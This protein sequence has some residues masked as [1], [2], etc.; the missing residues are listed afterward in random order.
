MTRASISR[1]ARRDRP[2]GISH[3]G[4]QAEDE[5]ELAEVYDRLARAERPT[6][7]AKATTCCYAKSDKQWIADPQGVPWETFFTYG[8]STVYGEGSL[9]KLKELSEAT[10]CGPEAMPQAASESAGVSACCAP[11]G[12]TAAMDDAQ[13][14]EMVRARYRGIA[15]AA[16][17][18]SCCAPA[19]SCCGDTAAGTQ[20]D[21]ARQMGYSDAELAVVP[22]G[23]NLGLG[24][25]NP[26]AIAALK[27][28]EVVVDL[29]SGA[30]FD[31][32]L[33]A[34]Q[35][36][37]GG[38]VIGVDMTHEMLKKARENAA[39]ISAANVEFRLGEL[40]HLPVADST[41]DAILSNCVINLVPDK[42]QVYREAFRVLKAGGRLAISDVVNTAPLTPEL[43]ADTALLC[44]CIA[45]ASPV[46]RVESWLTQAGFVDVR[47]TPQ[48]ESRELVASWAPGRGI[49]NFVASATVEA[50]KPGCTSR[51]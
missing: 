17:A 21:K 45:G 35:V 36:G 2:A 19:S 7:E 4:I 37:A 42:A 24:C 50:R 31:C 11:A 41:A 40:E 12:V 38:R 26:Q 29:G 30:G 15:E 49:E 14:K 6:L 47:V 25:G 34:R 33:A 27:P 44:G 8:E 1:L 46:E 10:C 16:G 9:A 23:A 51:G 20:A 13:I 39:K 32:F 22:D 3:L 18:D 5:A 28:G 48:S 43:Q